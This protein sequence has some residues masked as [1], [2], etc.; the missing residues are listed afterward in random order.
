MRVDDSAQHRVEH[1]CL[2]MLC[3]ADARQT[4][5]WL[6]GSTNKATQNEKFTTN[7]PFQVNAVFGPGRLHDR[8]TSFKSPVPSNQPSEAAS[9]PVQRVF[10]FPPAGFE[11]RSYIGS[12]GVIRFLNRKNRFICVRCSNRRILC[13]DPVPLSEGLRRWPSRRSRTSRFLNAL[14]EHGDAQ[15]VMGWYR[16]ARVCF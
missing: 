7:W 16:P 3:A 12:S 4:A 2:S 5:C 15:T 10:Q 13:H 1:F 9:L 6:S 14:E 8:A 11:A